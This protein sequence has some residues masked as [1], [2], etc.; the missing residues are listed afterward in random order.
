MSRSDGGFEFQNFVNQRSL[1]R[2]NSCERL[3]GISQ[4]I[5]IIQYRAPI[6]RLTNINIYLYL[7]FLYSYKKILK[8]KK[9]KKNNKILILCFSKFKMS[10]YVVLYISHPCEETLIS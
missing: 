10:D 8:A 5:T 7:I 1:G 9:Y 4:N 2:H 6:I 3:K